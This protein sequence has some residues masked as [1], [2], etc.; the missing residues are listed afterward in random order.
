MSHLSCKKLLD[1]R[2]PCY[3]SIIMIV[4]LLSGCS[5]HGAS[6]IP[7]LLEPVDLR[8]DTAVAYRGDL[9][10]TAYYDGWLVPEVE[11][12]AFEKNG[13]LSEIVVSIGDSIEQG[14]ILA[15][16]T[17]DGL[18][19]RMNVLESDME[20]LQKDYTYNKEE[21]EDRIRI[22]GLEYE[23]LAAAADK[24]IEAVR[25]KNEIETLEL[26]AKHISRQFDLR[27]SQMRTK[28]SGYQKEAARNILT[29]PC[30]GTV[31]AADYQ[32]TGR[33][34]AAD[35]AVIAIAKEEERYLQTEYIPDNI[36]KEAQ[37]TYAFIGDGKAD[38]V[39][40]AYGEREYI[41]KKLSGDILI[42]KF[43]FKDSTALSDYDT[44][45]Y[46]CICIKTRGAGNVVI[47][48]VEAVK[49]EPSGS[50][51]Y[52]LQ[53]GRQD[54]RKVT[55]GLKIAGQVEIVSG[56]EEGERVLLATAG[57][58]D[59]NDEQEELIRETVKG[60]YTE[61]YS[62][63]GL[64]RT[65]LTADVITMEHDMAEFLQYHAASGDAVSEGDVLME[66]R[67]PVNELELEEMRIRYQRTLTE[68]E[69]DKDNRRNK[70]QELKKAADKAASMSLQSYI[71]QIRI[72]MEERS[73]QRYCNETED[74]IR[75]LKDDLDDLEAGTG[76]QYLYAP[77][78][79]IILSVQPLSQGDV[80]SAG[81]GVINIF[82]PDSSVLMVQNMSGSLKYHMEVRIED[83]LS[84]LGGEKKL[85]SGRI[86]AADNILEGEL[87]M[88]YAVIRLDEKDADIS[89]D[90]SVIQAIT[91]SIA[92]VPV[93]PSEMLYYSG[94]I[95][96][97]YI[98]QDGVLEKRVV[99]GTD[100]GETVWIY[101]GLDAGE[102]VYARR[103]LPGSD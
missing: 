101:S 49:E 10:D 59:L 47:L 9:Y 64:E 22:A 65:Y 34:I 97:A 13:I 68:Y 87:A 80:M 67:L 25:K 41:S 26:E 29:A 88:G 81:M 53:D 56:I 32:N 99:Q 14:E 82:D 77:F 27:L 61:L 58:P 45:T 42:S 39:N 96:Y 83:K 43:L 21:L 102:K 48:P 76:V 4:C 11:Y 24:Y 72:S 37:E 79:G 5:R 86:I 78:D 30:K 57:L 89:L 85:Y 75:K 92:N 94:N 69:T 16:L 3:L 51:A 103:L 71:E 7:V 50:Y 23:Q 60:D 98:T 15:Y 74:S 73:F 62:A 2:L 20:K 35:K 19:D 17:D 44:G 36:I 46:A 90:A 33:N 54:K 8:Y 6:N 100:N 28:L 12:A 38:I 93:I 31:V 95:R 55:T 18:E 40:V 91:K 84:G 52:V 63:S 1:S 66:Y 70:L